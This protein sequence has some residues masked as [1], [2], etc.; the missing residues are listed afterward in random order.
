MCGGGR[1]V[2]GVIGGAVH[3]GDAAAEM[4]MVAVRLSDCLTTTTCEME[5]V[6]R[7]PL[8]ASFLFLFFVIIIFIYFK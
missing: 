4:G 7:D 5:I 1:W 8:V 3:G 2:V 6:D